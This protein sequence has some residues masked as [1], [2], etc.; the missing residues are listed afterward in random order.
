VNVRFMSESDQVAEVDADVV[1]AEGDLVNI[2]VGDMFEPHFV[3]RVEWSVGGPSGKPM[4]AWVQVA[5]VRFREGGG[6]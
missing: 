6:A 2:Y 4:I 1:P 5:P 3:V